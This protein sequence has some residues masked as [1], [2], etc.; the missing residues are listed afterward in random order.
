MCRSYWNNITVR[1]SHTVLDL[2]V[3]VPLHPV[4]CVCCVA[5]EVRSEHVRTESRKMRVTLLQLSLHLFEASSTCRQAGMETEK[6]LSERRKR[7][8]G[9]SELPGE[10]SEEKRGS[11]RLRTNEHG[12]ISEATLHSLMPLYVICSTESPRLRWFIRVTAG[13]CSCSAVVLRWIM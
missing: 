2:C 8:Q 5:C 9:V 7:R 1:S 3:C 12:G 4:S 6:S 10:K 11:Q 13:T